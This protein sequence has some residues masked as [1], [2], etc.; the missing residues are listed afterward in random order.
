MTDAVTQAREPSVPVDKL[1][2][3]FIKI[4]DS[5]EALS[6]K[7]EEDDGLL[8][9]Q[10]EVI[11]TQILE[12]CKELNLDS[13]KTTAGTATRSVKTRY[14]SSDWGAL[15][16]FVKE[17]D[18]MDLMERRVHQTNMKQFLA[19]NPD[20]RIPGLNSDSYYDITVRRSK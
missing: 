5:R 12:V 20:V 1:M 19:E 17:H 10:Q 3:I 9:D 6:R 18:A 4:R 16:E 13:L 15:H 11:K 7:Y 8:K 14:W 2:K